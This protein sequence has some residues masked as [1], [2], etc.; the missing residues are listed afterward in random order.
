MFGIK[1]VAKYI[2]T[3][4]LVGLAIQLR[5]WLLGS[6]EKNRMFVLVDQNT[7]RDAWWTGILLPNVEQ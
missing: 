1:G 6:Y 5:I 7:V 2:I 3:T 4:L